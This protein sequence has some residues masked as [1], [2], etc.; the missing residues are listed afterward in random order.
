MKL[1]TDQFIEL[2]KITPADDQ[3]GVLRHVFSFLENIDLY[4]KF[5]FPDVIRTEVPDF[6]RELYALYH[7]GRNIALAAP[8]GHAKSSTLGIV[9]VSWLVVNKAEKYIIYGSQNHAKSIQF[10]TPLRDLFKNNDRIKFVYGDLNPA[11]SKEEDGRDREDC[12]DVNGIRIEAFS[13]EKNL[14]GFK[15][16]AYRPTLICLDDIESDERVIN[17]EMREKDAHKLNKVIIPA[18]DANGRLVFIGTLLHQQSLLAEKIARYKGKVFKAIQDDGS[19]L[20]PQ[21]YSHAKLMQI[22]EDIGSLAFQQEFMNDPVD[23]E[24]AIIRQEWVRAC[25]DASVSSEDLRMKDKDQNWVFDYTSVTGGVDFA[26]SERLT[27]DKS[28]FVSL[29]A[30]NGKFYVLWNET[31]KGLSASQ[32]LDYIRL[33]WNTTIRHDWIGLEENSIKAVSKDLDQYNLPLKLFWT[34][35]RDPKKVNMNDMRRMTVGKINLIERLGV[36]FEHQRFVIPYK[37]DDDKR[38]AHALLT[39][40]T[41][42]ARMNGKLVESSV[43]P[44]IPIALGYALELLQ[45]ATAPIISWGDEVL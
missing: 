2:L 39:E 18:L 3:P 34:S 37:T 6:H 4:S 14:R 25:F 17:P 32:Q 27:A 40:C 15:F 12:I 29:G 10:I 11:Y 13:F 16:K 41:S 33:A 19:I 22:K 21:L 44:D 38:R 45:G 20:F 36:A 24:T 23:N 1:T 43:H 30:S 35:Q 28:A 9:Y 42:F 26:F 8:R 7:S 5:M 31:K